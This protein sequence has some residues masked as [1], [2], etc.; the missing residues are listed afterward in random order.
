MTCLF[1]RELLLVEQAE[2]HVGEVEWNERGVR[3]NPGHVA[4]ACE[5]TF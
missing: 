1:Y 2:C 4:D 5:G 3:A